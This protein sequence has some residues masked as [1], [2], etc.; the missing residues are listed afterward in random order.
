MQIDV[1]SQKKNPVSDGSIV[2]LLWIYDI[3]DRKRERKKKKDKY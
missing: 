1:I 2:N 3:S